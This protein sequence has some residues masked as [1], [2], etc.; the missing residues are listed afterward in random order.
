MDFV[1]RFPDSKL[2]KDA[3]DFLNQSQSQIKK[4]ANEQ[5]KTPA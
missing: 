5:A 1:D 2:R 4:I 3:E